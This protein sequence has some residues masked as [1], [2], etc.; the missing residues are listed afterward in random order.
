MSSGDILAVCDHQPATQV[1]VLHMEA[2]NHCLLSRREL[3]AQ[4]VEHGLTGR[5]RVPAD[6]ETLVWPLANS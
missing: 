2:F 5:V 6:G 3:Q 4:L 1:I